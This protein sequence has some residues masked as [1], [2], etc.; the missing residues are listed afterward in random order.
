MVAL[1]RYDILDTPSEAEFDDFTRLAAQ[2]CGTPVAQIT[3]VDS[4]RQ[5][6]KSNFGVDVPEV[7][8]DSGFCAHTI[9]G[10]GLFEIPNMLE[11]ERFRENPFVSGRPDVRFYA[12]APLVSSDGFNIGALCVLDTTPRT[13]TPEQR[14]SLKALGRQVMRLMESRIAGR[15]ERTLNADLRAS[16]TRN[17]ELNENLEGLVAERTAALEASEE[18]FRQFAEQSSEAFWFV[19]VNP[20]QVLYVSPAMGSICG[21][22]E[23]GS[24]AIPP[25]G[26]RSSIP[27]IR[28]KI[29]P[30][31]RAAVEGRSRTSRSSAASSGPT[32]LFAGWPSAAHPSRT[33]PEASS[34]S[35]AWSRTSPRRENWRRNCGRHRRSRASA[36]SRAVLHTISTTCSR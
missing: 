13:L 3:L 12:G 25:P 9:L 24:T 26:S 18:R 2:L 16:E 35:A 27:T 5:W 7:P 8:R 31:W 21:L 34:V 36:S 33:T 19:R 10:S 11:D 6:F 1:K 15:K 28:H 29:G 30:I 22:G 32:A 17:R 23:S 14:D 4:E 20:Q